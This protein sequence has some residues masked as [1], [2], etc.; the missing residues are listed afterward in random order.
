KGLIAFSDRLGVNPL[1]GGGIVLDL[2]GQITANRF[3]E[4]AILDRDMGMQAGAMHSA[5]GPLP[6]ELLLDGKDVFVIEAVAEVLQ[7]AVAV[8]PPFECLDVIGSLADPHRH[9]E[10]RPDDEELLED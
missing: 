7:R 2:D 3:N 1:P 8:E 9:V 6:L 5:V 4:D 10:M